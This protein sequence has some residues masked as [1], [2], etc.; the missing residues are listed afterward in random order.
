MDLDGLD[1]DEHNEEALTEVSEFIRVAAMLIYQE[2][3][4]ARASEPS[5]ES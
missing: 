4:V 3:V 2:R 1:D 5:P